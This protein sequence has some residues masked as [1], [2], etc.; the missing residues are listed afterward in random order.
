MKRHRTGRGSISA[1][2]VVWVS[3]LLNISDV[4]V[5]LAVALLTGS[6]TVLAQAL[7]G[8][9]DLLSSGLLLVG[10]KQSQRP[11]DRRHP[12]GYG[13]EL[14]F[15]SFFSG[16]ATF[17]VTAALSFYWGLQRFLAPEPI[18]NLPITYLAL[19]LSV[20]TN[21]Y[22]A[23]LSFRRLLGKRKISQLRDTFMHSALI[24]TKTTLVLD[25]MGTSA[26]LLGLT[27]LVIYGMT[28]DLRFDG[29]G[30]MMTGVALAFFAFFILKGA[31]ELLIG[32]SAGYE[33]EGKIKKAVIAFSEVINVLDLRTVVLGSERL[34]VNIEVHLKDGLTT[35]EIEKLVDRIE[36]KI[37]LAVPITLHIQIELETP[38]V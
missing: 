10:L 18:L 21:G 4:V 32:Q 31:K 29:V 25:V 15:W 3:F 20:T 7:E 37:R 26:S 12:Y 11:A 5:N 35:D 23:S 24:E 14:Y 33:I 22:A 28:G 34:L 17:G 27:A 9:A 19:I 2:R 36:K 38:D 1:R 13:R 16:L 8:G 30:A 6:V